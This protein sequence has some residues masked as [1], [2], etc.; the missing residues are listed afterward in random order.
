DDQSTTVPQLMERYQPGWLANRL[1]SGGIPGVRYL[2]QRSRAAGSG[3]SNYV[4]F[5]PGLL[6]IAGGEGVVA[7]PKSQDA[8]EQAQDAWEESKH[9]RGQP[10]NA[11]EFGPGGGKE[12]T[13]PKF[14]PKPNLG[15]LPP[16]AKE[17]ENTKIEVEKL[18]DESNKKFKTLM[19]AENDENRASYDK[20]D[21][22]FQEARKRLRELEA[23][24]FTG[25]D[26]PELEPIRHLVGDVCKDLGFE[27]TKVNLVL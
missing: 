1:S 20:V 16:R 10:G 15:N 26:D 19:E 8:A 24:P 11:G 14:K 25:Q 5:D 18:R 2:D 21:A 7:G 6:T 27:T 22:K 17:I 3:T 12:K 23:I 13:T 9:P 4:V